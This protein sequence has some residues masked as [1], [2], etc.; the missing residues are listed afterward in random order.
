MPCCDIYLFRTNFWFP[1]WKKASKTELTQSRSQRRLGLKRVN[2]KPQ[3]C[4]SKHDCGFISK[5]QSRPLLRIRNSNHWN[6]RKYVKVG[7]M[8]PEESVSRYILRT[9]T[10]FFIISILTN[11][12][13]NADKAS[14]III[15]FNESLSHFVVVTWPSHSTWHF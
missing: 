14:D 6:I 4:G 15:S 8:C 1:W 9:T 13:A 12:C 5:Q 10:I 3:N 11:Y 7:W 2:K